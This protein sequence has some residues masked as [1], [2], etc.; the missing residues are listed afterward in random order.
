MVGDDPP[1][2]KD[3]GDQK[4]QHKKRERV[5]LALSK[6]PLLLGDVEIVDCIKLDI[7][8]FTAQTSKH[9]VPRHRHAE[10]IGSYNHIFAWQL[11]RPRRYLTPLS[12]T[13]AQGQIVWVDLRDQQHSFINV[14]FADTSADIAPAQRGPDDEVTQDAE[15]ANVG[16]PSS[17]ATLVRA[18]SQTADAAAT[19]A[20]ERAAATTARGVGD[21]A[22]ARAMQLASQAASQ[23]KGD[24]PFGASR[25]WKLR[26]A[27]AR[28]RDPARAS[29]LAPPP[30][31]NSALAASTGLSPPKLLELAP[32]P[33]YGNTCFLNSVLQCLRAVCNR[34]GL[35]VSN[36][37]TCPLARLLT[38]PSDQRGEFRRRVLTC[39]LWKDLEIHRQH[40]AHEALRLL[41]DDAHAMHGKCTQHSCLARTLSEHFQVSFQNHLA[42]TKPRCAWHS[43]PPAEPGCDVSIEIK[44]ADLQTLLSDFEMPAF[45]ASQDD[46]VCQACGDLVQK[47]ISVQPVGRA[48]LLHLKRFAFH[49]D[50][51]KRN[52]PVTFPRSLVFGS[53]RYDFSAMVEHIGDTGRAGHYIAHVNSS[54]SLWQCDDAIVTEVTWERVSDRQPYLIAYVRT[55][56]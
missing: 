21:V 51:R 10:I 27:L 42:C 41:L 4:H 56:V 31:T 7:A 25:A 55:D 15:E 50:G 3:V 44:P 39:P 46:Y 28:S 17:A 19:A 6:H 14:Q 1:W 20:E 45:L 18:Q 26:E 37:S 13:R 23:H 43:T 29:L 30:I 53:V 33:N 52:D 48:L 35:A 47:T 36:D 2:Q 16:H 12:Y 38:V 5:A 11:S 49:G 40:D 32:L 24:A 34:V 22:Q 54:G 8:T 9:G